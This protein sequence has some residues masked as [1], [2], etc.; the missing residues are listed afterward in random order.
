MIGFLSEDAF[1]D[2]FPPIE[3]SKSDF[4]RKFR[5][6]YK[7]N[8]TLYDILNPDNITNKRS[9]IKSLDDQ[10]YVNRDR[11]VDYFYDVVIVHRHEYLKQFYKSYFRVGD[12]YRLKWNNDP[13]VGRPRPTSPL[14]KSRRIDGD[15]IKEFNSPSCSQ[16][17]RE[18]LLEGWISDL[19][20]V[21]I[22]KNDAARILIRNLNYLDILH[23]TRIT[24]TSKCKVSF[25]QTL[26]NVYN[27]LSLED[28]FFAPSSIGLYLREKK[29]QAINYNNFFYLIQQ[30]Q[31][32]ASILNPFTIY[33]ILE[34]YF[35]GRHLFTPVL[36]WSSYLMAF[37]HSNYQTYVGVDVMP[38]VCRRAEYLTGYYN[39]IRPETERRKV[40]IWCQPSESLSKSAEFMDKYEGFFDSV[41]WCPPYF[42]MEIYAGEDQSISSYPDYDEW[43]THYFEA[44]VR[45]CHEVTRTGAI[46]GVIMND[47]YTLDGLYYPL[48]NDFNQVLVRHFELIHIVELVNRTSPLRVNKKNRT[49]KLFIY[50]KGGPP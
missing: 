38:D 27:K 47:Y 8:P 34:R 33:W 19:E 14:V 4:C 35:R 21:S 48:I 7:N 2:H 24:N 17:R 16:E 40:D 25:W 50:R 20:R 49:E 13:L 32:K 43:L 28:R 6:T 30:Y 15:E 36:S 46:V 31:P 44:T 39:S 3:I 41:L 29:G 18:S 9:V 37:F 22:Q 45:L 42:D 1:L 5:V 23:T 10:R 26:I 12:P 11:V